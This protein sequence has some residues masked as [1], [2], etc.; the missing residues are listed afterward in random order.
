MIDRWRRIGDLTIAHGDPSPETRE[1]LDTFAASMNDDLNIAGAIAA[2][3]TWSS[4][5]LR[6]SSGD[7]AAIR[8]FDG[9]LGVLSLERAQST[10]SDIGIFVGGLAPDPTVIAKLEDRRAARA[11][12]DF[13][14]SDQ[15]R[16][17]LLAM[18]YA[19]KDAPGGK[20]EVSRK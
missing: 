15:I 10:T 2:I 13:K 14:K 20:V 12:K 8:A 7:V 19:I 3:N 16:D 1:A 11:A 9:V 6:P 4:K 17:D 5:I 18:G